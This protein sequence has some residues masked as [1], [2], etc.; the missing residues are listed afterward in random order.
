MKAKISNEKLEAISLITSKNLTSPSNAYTP[1]LFK[2]IA[3]LAL[4]LF[5]A[6]IWTFSTCQ[7]TLVGHTMGYWIAGSLIICLLPLNGQEMTL[8]DFVI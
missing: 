1:L 6:I 8:T 7:K 3:C 2:N 5:N 4:F